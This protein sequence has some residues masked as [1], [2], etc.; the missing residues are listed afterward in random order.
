MEILMT[1]FFVERWTGPH[2]KKDLDAI[3]FLN[4]EELK[5]TREMTWG[6]F[7]TFL[8]NPHI[9]FVVARRT[10]TEEIIGKQTMYMVLL[11]DGEI[12]TYLEQVATHPAYKRMGI[13]KEILGVLK[14]IAHDKGAEFCDFSSNVEKEAAQKFYN[15]IP[16]CERRKT[17][18]FRI[19]L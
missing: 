10:D 17:N 12:K 14:Q 15:S 5:Q 8:K 2:T 9:I 7:I 1:E 13:G 18:N 4:K 3:N 6:Q 11:D 19:R 16:G